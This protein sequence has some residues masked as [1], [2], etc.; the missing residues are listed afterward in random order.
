MPTFLP[1]LL[2][3]VSVFPRE[4]RF[5]FYFLKFLRDME[6]WKRDR[7]NFLS[8]FGDTSLVVSCPSFSSSPNTSSLL[9]TFLFSMSYLL[10]D[11]WKVVAYSASTGSCKR[12]E[13][14]V[15][16]KVVTGATLPRGGGFPLSLIPG[17]LPLRPSYAVSRNLPTSDF[18]Q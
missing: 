4:F 7:R 3:F 17:C 15:E 6:S 11:A 12:M 1:A 2:H 14:R 8:F 18:F 13:W 16:K 5:G 10:T 9:Q